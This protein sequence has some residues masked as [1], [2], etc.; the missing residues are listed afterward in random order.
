MS[1]PTT[2]RAGPGVRLK[3]ATAN[4][5]DR[6]LEMVGRFHAEAGIDVDDARREPAVAGLL[7]PYST[8]GRIYLM[9]ADSECAGYLALCF[10]YSIELGGRDAGAEQRRQEM[11]M[12]G[13]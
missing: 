7:A 9:Y 8:A 2:R 6:L 10:G 5:G 12:G 1:G 3:V 13:E 11:G 4:D